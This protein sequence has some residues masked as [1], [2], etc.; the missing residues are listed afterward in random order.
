[1]KSFPIDAVRAEFPALIVS[2]GGTP[3]VYLDN[4]AGT[5][6][7]RRV[8]DAAARCLLESN[9]NLGGYFTTS[10]LAQAQV[11][12]AHEA[13]AHMLGANSMREIIIGQ[14]MTTLTFHFSRSIGRTLNP[15]DEI[16]VTR[17]DHDGNIAPWLTMA[18]DR[19][20]TVRWLDFDRTSWRIEAAALDGVLNSRTRLV[21]LNYANNL[22]GS[23]NDV[24]ALVARIHQAGALAYVDAVQF[25]PHDFIDVNAIGCDLLACSAYKFFGPHVGI[26]WG[27][28]ALLQELVPDKVRPAT[29]ELPW[30]WETGT[31]QIEVQAALGATV[32][33]F[34]WLGSQCGATGNERDCIQA[35]FAASSQYE[36]DLVERLIRGLL[37]IPGVEILGITDMQR[38]ERRVPTVSFTQKDRTTHEIAKALAAKNIFVWSGNNFAL[39]TVR[40]LGL[41]EDAGAVRIGLAHYNTAEE[42][43]A[44]LE[45]LSSQKVPA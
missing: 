25:A 40:S 32:D 6:V 7:P 27:R 37:G 19:G 10:L 22:T 39:E 36:R 26:V 13:M 15:G 42:V 34:A 30:R 8:A 11:D 1:M 45:A 12:R 16:V 17:M 23:V 9:A 14:S 4:P 29:D 18:Q 33:Y 24:H 5:Q 28:E 35:A 43:D 21:A 31:P 44:A 2:D 38:L 41:D 3:R 20:L